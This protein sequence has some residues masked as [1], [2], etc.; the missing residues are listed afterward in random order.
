MV[1]LVSELVDVLCTW[2]PNYCSARV[3][4]HSGAL[5]RGHCYK[6]EANKNY[7]WERTRIARVRL[8][9]GSCQVSENRVRFLFGFCD[10]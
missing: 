6:A 5:R 9:S 10:Y 2:Q 1:A 7:R 4:V 3:A 8:C